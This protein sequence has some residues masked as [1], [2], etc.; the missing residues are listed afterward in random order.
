MKGKGL[1]IVLGGPP[2]GSASEPDE[3]DAGPSD[4]EVATANELMAAIKSG[5]G[6]TVATALKNF[7]KECGAY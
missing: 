4:E 2:K 3:D 7:L 6:G 1:A 5:D